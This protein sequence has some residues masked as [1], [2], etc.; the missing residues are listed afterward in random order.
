MGQMGA[1]SKTYSIVGGEHYRIDALCRG[2]GISNP[3]A[4]RYIEVFFE[5]D[6]KKMVI[7]QRTGDYSRPFYPWAEGNKEWVKFEGTVY[8]PR[9]QLMQPFDCSLGGS[10]NC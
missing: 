1:W 8:A 3:R 5:D 9:M 7:D 2:S 6:D 4:N 10:H